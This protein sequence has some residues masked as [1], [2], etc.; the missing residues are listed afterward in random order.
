M[1]RWRS[2]SRRGGRGVDASLYVRG[3]ANDAAPSWCGPE[4]DAVTSQGPR[5]TQPCEGEGDAETRR[6]EARRGKMAGLGAWTT[7]KGRLRG[8]SLRRGRALPPSVDCL[9]VKGPRRERR[10]ATGAG[11]SGPRGFIVQ[12]ARLHKLEA[13]AAGR[14]MQHGSAWLPANVARYYSEVTWLTGTWGVRTRWAQK[15]RTLDPRNRRPLSHQ[16]Q[17]P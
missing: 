4:V 8:Q 16:P 1:G 9:V 15:T 5:R 12:N 10:G 2:S 17:Q 13:T 7:Q 6:G 14:R 11:A 3:R